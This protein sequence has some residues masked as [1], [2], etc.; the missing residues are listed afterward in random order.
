[1]LRQQGNHDGASDDGLD[2]SFCYV[3]TAKRTMQF[4]GAMQSLLYTTEEEVVE[5]KGDRQSIGY[6][7][8]AEDYDYSA[9]QIHLVEGQTFY[10]AS[11]GYKDMA[12]GKDGY[13]LGKRRLR[14]FINS[15]REKSLSEQY[16]VL[17]NLMNE[18]VAK[19]GQLDD[20]TMIGFR[21][22]V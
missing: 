1:M 2:A 14:E 12:V 10:L 19:N 15:V 5:V 20:I 7:S 8:S 6:I 18:S 9:H 4:S 13:I 17:L 11:D 16:S 21:V 22:K 3:D